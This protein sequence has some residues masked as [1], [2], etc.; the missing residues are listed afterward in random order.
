MVSHGYFAPVRRLPGDHTTMLLLRAAALTVLALLLNAC[1]GGGA[2]GGSTP[3]ATPSPPPPPA[4]ATLSG[5]LAEGQALGN[6][7]V[8]L[9]SAEGTELT[10]SITGADGAYT[11]RIPSTAEAPLELRGA[12]LRALLPQ[13][14][15]AGGSATAHI[16]PITEAVRASLTES[17]PTTL[18][19]L[20][21]AGNAF[22][23]QALG[24]VPYGRFASDP[25]FRARSANQSGNAADVLLDA[26]AVLAGAERNT[27][28]IALGRWAEDG[29]G[30]GDNPAL[31]LLLTY[32]LLQG[33][34]SL[35]S[36]SDRF[37]ELNLEARLN[38]PTVDQAEALLALSDSAPLGL[39][40]L[41]LNGTLLTLATLNGEGSVAPA[42]AIAP[43]LATFEDALAN[44]VLTAIVDPERD[45]ELL[46]RTASAAERFGRLL[47]PLPPESLA[48]P[49]NTPLLTLALGASSVGGSLLTDL[50]A[51]PADGLPAPLDVSTRAEAEAALQGLL[52][53]APELA[54]VADLD[55]DGTPFADDAFPFDPEEALDSDNDGLGNN[56]DPDDD[57]DGI[58]DTDDSD[59]LDPTRAA[60][61]VQFSVSALE[62]PAPAILTFDASASLPGTANDR[63]ERFAWDFGDGEGGLG[64]LISHRYGAAG[65]YPVSLTVS[66]SAGLSASRQAT[67]KVLPGVA[68][69]SMSGF[70]E[71]ASSN[72]VDSDLNDPDS[73][74]IPNNRLADAQPIAT[75]TQ[76]GG[77][78]TVPRGGASGPLFAAG[79]AIDYFRFDAAGGE[80]IDLNIADKDAL[81]IDLY[82]LTLDGVEVDAS[83]NLGSREQVVVPE[84]GAYLLSVEIFDGTGGSNYILQL[85]TQALGASLDPTL[86]RSSDD[87]LP[88]ELLFLPKA[89]APAAAA[90]KL[91]VLTQGLPSDLGGPV[92]RLKLPAEGAASALTRAPALGTPRARSAKSA[93]LRAAKTLQRTGAV[94]YA[95]PNYRRRAFTVPNDP[96]Y[97]VQW[98][99]DA[100]KLPEAW[101]LT[102]GSDDVVVAVIDTGII[103][104]PDLRSRL[105]PGYDFIADADNAGDGDGIDANPNDP[106]DACGGLFPS[107][108][109]GTHVA[110]TIG[111]ATNNGAGVAGVTWAGK[112]MPLRVLG[113]EGGSSFDIVQ[114]VRFAAGL[115]NASNTVPAQ[116][117]DIINL[118]LGGAGGSLSE[119]QAFL[120]AQAA[121]SLIIAA[122][123]NEGSS[124]PNFP[125]AYDGVI[126]VSA[127]TIDDRL[128]SY[129]N[130]GS[131]IDVAAPGGDNTADLN[132][133]AQPDLVLSTD[134]EDD[135][136]ITPSIEFKAGTSMAAPHVAGVAALMKALLPA[137]TPSTFAQALEAGQLTD[138]LGE[139][140]RD[141]FF[142][143]GRINALK[144]VRYAQA[145]ASGEEPPAPL[146]LR[147]SP[148]SV[149]FGRSTTEFELTITAT[150][151]GS[152]GT[153]A[154]T[155]ADPAL[156]ITPVPTDP[157]TPWR[158]LLTLDRTALPFGSFASRLEANLGS[159]S[160]PISVRYE[161]ADPERAL[162][163]TAGV[164]FVLALDPVS[165]DTIAQATVL[166]PVNGRYPFTLPNLAPGTYELV[167]GTDM[168]GDF[169]L[170]DPGEAFGG[171]PTLDQLEEITVNGEVTGL[172]FPMVFQF[173]D[174]QT[175]ST[176]PGKNGSGGRAQRLR[177]ESTQKQLAP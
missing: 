100:I 110:G 40:A 96:A 97:P 126:S 107:S 60:P 35:G 124:V 67:V 161:N 54:A 75:P 92:R 101:D 46:S 39:T 158:F 10:R 132:G 50:L 1:G 91:E 25:A 59:P 20:T 121:G 128:A 159:S 90:G 152:D 55:G 9:H 147:A 87:F 103:D 2:G 102:T 148:S 15:S 8:S 98:H 56:A 78:L 156:T 49:S 163:A 104:H 109:H 41:P 162:E 143:I 89:A 6:T 157:G 88:G 113:C 28:T 120:E 13:I 3:P 21:A 117:A 167:A 47:A 24:P 7:V 37:A 32:G 68:T 145:V 38:D 85:S 129:S 153:L 63:F 14:P 53:D 58:A 79:D 4:L 23:E 119:E 105:V 33:G 125:A 106:G 155:T 150:G 5:V 123:G 18:S 48:A 173:I 27:L 71:I 34:T 169:F 172:S 80:V 51:G 99:Y 114:A 30:P 127:T 165:G 36:L 141:D 69:V 151:D 112:I 144:A 140:G 17:S 64:Q 22:L 45:R 108:F 83:I 95:E 170:G 19:A 116:P 72:N 62:A 43:L 81:D 174:A 131:T 84:P 137:L 66:N 11:L 135:G 177:I 74:V 122:A 70:V 12:G 142:G 31:P 138:D 115:S 171:F 26:L 73:I 77:Y 86:R 164:V 118:S 176:W 76:L 111:A 175:A 136:A 65:T 154:L 94:A 44:L 134:G 149:N 61:V 29:S 82:L 160:L 166:A 133:D 168:D 139:A 16:N 146:V 42:A 130:F 57:G 52:A 93:V